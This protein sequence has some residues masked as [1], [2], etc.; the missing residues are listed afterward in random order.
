M[1]PVT[2]A[3][4]IHPSYEKDRS[5]GMTTK[6]LDA[7][8]EIVLPLSQHIGAPARPCVEKGDEVLVG[9]TIGEPG[10]FVSCP[11]HSSVSGKVTG[12]APR[13]GVMGQPVMSVII[14]NDEQDNAIEY[15]GLGDDWQGAD[16]EKLKQMIQ[17]AGLVGMGGAAFPTHVKL[18]PPKEKPIDTA[19]LN[20]AECEPF[21]T[22][23]HRTML[24]KP[25]DVARG[26][27]IVMKILGASKGIIGIETNKKDAIDAITAA[28]DDPNVDV[29]PLAVKYPQGAEKQLID[30]CIERQVP[31]GG[32]PMDVGVVVQNVGTAAAIAD[33]VMRGRPLIERVLTVTGP[34]VSE[35]ANLLGRLGTPVAHAIEACGGTSGPLGKLIMGGPMMGLAQHTDQV[36]ITKGTSGILLL[37]TEQVDTRSPDPCIRCGRCVTACPMRLVPTE[38]AS[39]AAKDMMEEAEQCDA[40]DCIECGSCAFDCPSRIAL[41]QGIRLAKAAI[42]AAKRKKS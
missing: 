35:P 27:T 3:G 25:E 20:G 36:P 29:M 7:P 30:A 19:I 40:L 23:D 42:M 26:L 8:K 13:P 18:S 24:E 14:E 5:S 16:V 39:Y 9:Q 2:F 37:G 17:E 41:V 31:S 21:L 32:L 34:A 38:I 28:V 1:R 11:V 6:P 10:G 4:G 15:H 22:A 33:A 12:I